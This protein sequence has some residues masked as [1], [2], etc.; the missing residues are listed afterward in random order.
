MAAELAENFYTAPPA[1]TKTIG[2]GHTKTSSR[3]GNNVLR[4][5]VESEFKEFFNAA[6]EETAIKNNFH[7]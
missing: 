2:L 4:Y 3:G 5:K 6:A 1:V 7:I